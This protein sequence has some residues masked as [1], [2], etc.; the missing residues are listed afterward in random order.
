[1]SRYSK[2]LEL[3]TGVAA[4]LL[5][6]NQARAASTQVSEVKIQP[7]ETSVELILQTTA[8]K[9]NPLK[10]F[11]LD[12]GK[13]LVADILNSELAIKEGKSFRQEKPFPGI[14]AVEVSQV[15]SNNIR[16]TVTGED[17]A[18]KG[19]VLQQ[20]TGGVIFSLTPSNNSPAEAQLPTPMS[21]IPSINQTPEP[22]A[23]PPSNPDV[24]VPDPEITIDG[25]VPP[26]AAP[27]PPFLPRAVAPPVGDIAVSNIDSTPSNLSLGTNARVPRLVLKDAPVREV[28]GLL[29]R[30]ANLNL[31]FGGGQGGE[32]PQAIPTISLDL[33]DQSVEE[34]FNSVLL[35]SGLQANRRGNTIF[36]G[37]ALPDQARNV[38]TRTFR[39]NQVKAENA[40]AFLASQGAAVQR[41]FT[42]IEE[43]V[44]PVTQRV[45]RTVAR[46]AELKPLT[47]QKTPGDTSPLLLQGLTVTTD[48]RLN[49]ISMVGEP[50]QIQIATNFLTQLDARRRQV[51]VNVK[52]IDVNLANTDEFNASVSF[53]IGDGFFLSDKGAA[54]F[55]YGGVN[56][57]GADTTSLS[58]SFPR[59]T[60]FPTP[61]GAR[62]EP[63][64]D[65]QNDAPFSDIN[66]AFGV[67]YARPNFGT[68]SNPFQPGVVSVGDDGTVTFSLP[69]LFEVPSKFLALLNAKITSG[70]A[71]ILTDPTLVVQEGQEATVKLVQEVLTSITTSIDSESGTRTVTPVIGEAGLTL[72]VNVDR[73]DDNGFISVSVSPTVSAIGDTIE[74][75]SGGAPNTLSLLSKREVSSGLLRLRDG[76]TLILSGII[77]DQDR[78]TVSKV[79]ILGDI[80]ILGALFRSTDRR[81]SRNEVIVLLTPQILDDSTRS[82]WG[83]NYSPGKAA[84]EVLQQQGI[85]VPNNP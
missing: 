9:D 42:P 73:I 32:T 15:D 57:P 70:N 53:G 21:Q 8:N 10:I 17:G 14:A 1:M 31:V 45:V 30:S 11:T 6:A 36:V 33:E 48:D 39:L 74:F 68:T 64:L 67:P 37:T 54:V 13:D 7:R 71:K 69:G 26:S 50:R 35:V 25:G 16:V 82:G 2:Y 3:W 51:A 23:P 81:N 41:I 65:I 20:E 19:Q 22:Q 29:A 38:I 49:S 78:T 55:N 44:D 4:V 34:V 84:G 58:G 40:A 66:Q 12:R 24:M 43:I 18:P 56:P 76:Q 27:T 59:V 62:I 77:Q 75:D 85:P 5:V 60:A 72:T 28:L 52:V 47:V 61:P 83:Y 79:P 46:P 80:P 63:F